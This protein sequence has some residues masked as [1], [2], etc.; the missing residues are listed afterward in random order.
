MLKKVLKKMWDNLHRLRSRRVI[1][2][3]QRKS[4]LQKGSP[5]H[6][7]RDDDDDDDACIISNTNPNI[8]LS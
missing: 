2:P 4:T 7:Y 8:S 6:M 1:L 3:A 5:T